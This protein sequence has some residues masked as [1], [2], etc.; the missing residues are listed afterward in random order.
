MQYPEE[1]LCL[2][3]ELCDFCEQ[4]SLIKGILLVGSYAS[5]DF[6]A[7]E[8]IDL[9]ILSDSPQK[10]IDETSWADEFGIVLSK[11]KGQFGPIQGLKVKYSDKEVDFGITS[12]DWS[13]LTP[14]SAETQEIIKKGAKIIFDPHEYLKNLLEKMY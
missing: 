8:D 1:V 5:G 6:T 9:V 7:S 14:L 4:S 10:L 13:S 11:K 2:F 3:D 12:T